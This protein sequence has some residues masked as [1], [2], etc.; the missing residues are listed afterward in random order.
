MF[1]YLLISHLIGFL[2]LQPQSPDN[3]IIK[4]S[5]WQS[6]I[7]TREKF[8]EK[9]INELSQ[10]LKNAMN[11]AAEFGSDFLVAPEGTLPL[12][13]RGENKIIPLISGGFRLV[14][15]NQRIGQIT[16]RYRYR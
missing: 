7:P 16:I 4:L 15:G 12:Y 13:W 14:E 10:N 8:S 2:I 11:H 5:S 9:R 6:Q 1:P 3:H